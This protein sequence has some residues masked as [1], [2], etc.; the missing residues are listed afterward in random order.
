[1]PVPGGRRGHAPGSR[2]PP[3]AYPQ[4]RRPARLPGAARRPGAAS[5]SPTGLAGWKTAAGQLRRG[6]AVPG[7]VVQRHDVV[8]H[9]RIIDLA[10]SVWH[11]VV[12][13]EVAHFQHYQGLPAAT[14]AV[15]AAGIRAGDAYGLRPD[16]RARGRGPQDPSNNSPRCRCGD[17]DP[18]WTHT[19]HTSTG[20]SAWPA[21]LALYHWSKCG[22]MA[23]NSAAN[24]CRMSSLLLAKNARTGW[25]NSAG[26][27][28]ASAGPPPPSVS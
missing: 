28:T 20:A 3:G 26:S 1:M 7:H 15:Q 21:C 18:F 23:R 9:C 22:N 4:Q 5:A 24:S 13:A 25:L 12:V 11:S 27:R 10:E 19:F 16:P 8:P 14:R 6:I 17:R 2:G